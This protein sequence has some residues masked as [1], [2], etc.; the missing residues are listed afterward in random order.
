MIEIKKRGSDPK[1]RDKNRELALL[2]ENQ[3][4]RSELREVYLKYRHLV[5]GVFELHDKLVRKPERV[6][7][8]VL[9]VERIEDVVGN[10]KIAVQLLLHDI[11]SLR[12]EY[13]KLVLRFINFKKGFSDGFE[14][15]NEDFEGS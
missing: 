1:S 3:R 15:E 12:L 6:F 2:Q 14:D 5:Q 10:I 11:E 8:P 4:L 9:R 7:Q 13:G